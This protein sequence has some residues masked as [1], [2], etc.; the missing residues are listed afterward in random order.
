MSDQAAGLRRLLGQSGLQVITVLSAQPGTGKTTATINLA[1]ALRRAGRDVLIL[2]QHPQQRG[3]TARLGLTPQYS[4]MDAA[5]GNCALDDLILEDAS[6]LKVLPLGGGFDALTQLPLATQDFLEERFTQLQCGVDI[7]LVDMEEA[8]DPDALPLGLVASEIL[9]VLPPG[10]EAIM[11]G[12]A[13]VKRLVRNYGKQQFRLL[14]NH[15]ATPR[16]A[17]AIARNFA[18]AAEQYLDASVEYLGSIPLDEQL[19]ATT[20]L[21]LAA[22]GDT[23]PRSANPTFR[24]LAELLLHWTPLRGL[25]GLGGFMQHTIQGSRLLD[26]CRRGG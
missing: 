24:K 26:A 18:A 6:G 19:G 3:A 13:L 12:Y 16:Q 7:V 21:P 14:I 25:S 17:E 22:W 8:T 20:A 23:A 15:G 11:Q 1:A 9:L 5:N 10:R 4:V 2:D